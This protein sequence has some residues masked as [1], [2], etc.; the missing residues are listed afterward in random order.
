MRSALTLLV[1]A[2]SIG[3]LAEVA[4]AQHKYIFPQFTF[5]GGWGSTLTVLT[6]IDDATTCKFSAQGRVLTMRDHGDNL[7][8]GTELTL[9]GA[10]NLL[11]TESQD[12]EASS[13]MAV[14]DCDKEVI[15]ANTLFW[16]KVGGS[17]VGEA[18]VE[19]SEQ[20]AAASDSYVWFPADYRDG[21]RFGVA[22]A[23]PSNESLDVQVLVTGIDLEEFVR[24]TVNVPANSAKAFFVDELGT[25]PTGHVVQVLISPSNNPGPSV[26]AVGLRFTGQVFTTIPGTVFGPTTSSSNPPPG[27]GPPQTTTPQPATV[28]EAFKLLNQ[29]TF[30]A[31]ER[32][33]QSVI[34]VGFEDWIEQQFQQPES[35]QMPHL[36]SLPAPDRLP[37][38][39]RDRRDI[40]F[41]NVITGPD[42]L[43]QRVAF[44]LS[45]IMVVAESGVL[46]QMPYGLAG[47]YDIL[48]RNAFGNFRDL[49]EEV[50]LHPAMGVYLSMLGN[51]RPDPSRNIS[52]DENY[53]REL[54]QLFTIGLVEL[55]I[56]GT[57]R[58]DAEGQPVPTYNQD[59]VEGFAHVFTGWNYAGG[60]NFNRARRN[61]TSQTLP[62]RLYP[63]FHATGTKLLLNGV[64]LPAGQTGRQDLEDA[65]DNIFAHPNVGPFLAIRLIQRL[66]TSNPSPEYVA[67]VATTFN[68]NGEGTRGDLKAVVKSILL[69]PE[70]RS[71]VPSQSS[72]KLKEPLLRLTQLWRAY[73]AR[74]ADG[75]YYYD[76]INEFSQS[77][78]QAPSV[79]NFFSPFYAP[80]GEISDA[81]LTAPEMQIS[82]E[83][84]NTLVTNFFYRQAFVS[85]S[86]NGDLDSGDIYIDIEEEVMLADDTD[87][88]VDR[89]AE[90]LLAGQISAT[91]RTE[92]RGMVERRSERDVARR[93]G[94]AIYLTVT[95][96]EF[97]R[98]H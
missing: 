58:T 68:D 15:S 53:A 94:E 37:R 92:I 21:A 74:S 46:R 82:T 60:A 62:M 17:L 30:G 2:V 43:R 31:T 9:Q 51:E 98:Q 67:R 4:F 65:L 54:M 35:L 32:E 80:P 18:L 33:V 91:L 16:W 59:I 69:D 49:M 10:F 14:L 81:G 66:V 19:P 93:V 3:G 75:S 47:Y 28:A 97:A 85:H 24:T 25:I 44:A 29:A 5:G 71:S 86:R 77:P 22:V 73:G 26:Y 83:Y 79:F 89:V 11:K 56:D 27:T 88:L 57:M 1:L 12:M 96:P 20:V 8:T 34:D 52:P 7:R 36:Q 72:G 50:T 61:E 48:T 63:E 90:K 70:A 6:D 13:G 23:N 41:R 55:N 64:R 84:G 95:S 76:P 39:Q 45:E 40:W 42:Q 38:L 87:A 78:L